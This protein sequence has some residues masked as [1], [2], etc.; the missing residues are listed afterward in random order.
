ML[1]FLF[2][3][4]AGLRTPLVAAFGYINQSKIFCEITASKFQG[5]PAAQFNFCTYE[6]LC[7]ATKT[8]THH[9]FSNRLLQNFRT[10]TFESNFF[11]GGG[12]GRGGLLLERLEAQEK[13]Q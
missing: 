6:G 2:K 7:P 3:N 1:E 9:R 13:D 5:Q 10:A 11:L 4:V 8:E 12:W